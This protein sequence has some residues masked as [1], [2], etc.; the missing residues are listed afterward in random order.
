LNEFLLF[1]PKREST[2]AGIA[3]TCSGRLIAGV[4]GAKRMRMQSTTQPAICA[5]E[6]PFRGA[7]FRRRTVFSIV[8]NPRLSHL[9]GL[10]RIVIADDDTFS[11]TLT[12]LTL[13]RSGYEVI[14]VE[15]GRL[16]MD[17]LSGPGAP[18]LA[19]LDWVMP[20]M[21]GPDV[22]R[23]IRARPDRSYI[24]IVL[25]TS[26]ESKADLVAGLEAGAD[27]YLTKPCHYDELMARLRT[28]QRILDLQDRLVFDARHD[29]LTLLPNRAGFMDRLARCVDRAKKNR[30]YRF[31]VLFVDLDRF[32]SVNDNLGHPAGDELLVQVGERLLLSIRGNDAVAHASGTQPIERGPHEDMLARIGGDEYA[33][34][35]DDI[36]SA[37]DAMKVARRI[38]NELTPAFDIAGRR[39]HI[40]A[41]VGISLNAAGCGDAEGMLRDADAAMYRSKAAGSVATARKLNYKQRA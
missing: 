24:Y 3:A 14:A 30:D 20:G 32:K 34:L 33:I 41:S 38:R 27:D 9:R 2:S 19:L 7:R 39:F 8:P 4:N 31:A 21:D 23:A 1:S 28:G 36:R 26:K 16:A 6:L 11:R 40:S 15:N 29:S 22:C 35:L 12:R 37:A 13:E 10:M 18:R 25:L 5:H 17:R